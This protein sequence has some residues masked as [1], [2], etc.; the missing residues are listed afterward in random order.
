MACVVI[1]PSVSL[2]QVTW[3]GAGANQNYLTQGFPLSILPFTLPV[4]SNFKYSYA[5]QA[6][7]TVEK[8]IAG[9]VPPPG[10]D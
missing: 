3:T 7:L 9:F 10:F 2:G 4:A 1:A 8:E 6:N 5:Q